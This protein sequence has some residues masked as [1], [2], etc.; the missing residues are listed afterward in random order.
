MD[1]DDVLLAHAWLPE[2]AGGPAASPLPGKEGRTGSGGGCRD[3][4]RGRGRWTSCAALAKQ[5]G[6]PGGEWGPQGAQ[7]SPKADRGRVLWKRV[8]VR[9]GGRRPGSVRPEKAAP[10]G[11]GGPGAAHRMRNG[12]LSAPPSSARRSP[13]RASRARRHPLEQDSVKR[14]PPSASCLLRRLPLEE[15]GEHGD[16]GPGE[17]GAPLSGRSGPVH[18]LARRH[19][20]RQSYLIRRRWGLLDMGAVGGEVQLPPVPGVPVGAP[21]MSC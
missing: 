3:G 7:P 9:R 18:D 10:D 6:D 11:V 15:P 4:T 5:G 20:E 17:D 1:E 13:K 8:S 12:E 2:E 21:G 16:G 14:S 19:V